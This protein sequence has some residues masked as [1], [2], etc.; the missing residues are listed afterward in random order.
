MSTDTNQTPTD[1]RGHRMVD[2]TFEKI[3][4]VTDVIY[5]DTMYDDMRDASTTG[6]PPTPT[7]TW[8]VV[9]PGML[10]AEHYVPVADSYH[11]ETGEIV[12][13]WE[14]R[15]VT[16]APKADKDHVLTDDVRRALTSH[17]VH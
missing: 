2:A 6:A 1:Y 16:S 12:V 5:D 3:G 17:Y 8:L 15:R 7:P 4:T 14:K 13:P 11:S 9:D 10:R